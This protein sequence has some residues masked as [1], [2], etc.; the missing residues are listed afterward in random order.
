MAPDQADE[1]DRCVL[2]PGQVAGF[3]DGNEPLSVVIDQPG[4]GVVIVVVGG[5]IDQVTASTLQNCLRR[6]VVYGPKHVV[7]DLR[8]VSL[9]SAAGC[10]C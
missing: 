5:P 10:P 1:S 3:V 8:R 6:V 2:P 9:L 7:I 4:P